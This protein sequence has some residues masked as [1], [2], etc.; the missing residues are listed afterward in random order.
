MSSM[1]PPTAISSGRLDDGNDE[2]KKRV[3]LTNPETERGA[4]FLTDQMAKNRSR[5]L[6]PRCPA[7]IDYMLGCSLIITNH[8]E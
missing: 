6:F 1:H 3:V 7:N 2:N 5:W 8:D 4:V